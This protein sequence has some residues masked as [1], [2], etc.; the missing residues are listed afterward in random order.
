MPLPSFLHAVV[1]EPRIASGLFADLTDDEAAFCVAAFGDGS[2][3]LDIA[4]HL[5]RH[6]SV[7]YRA[8]H[9]AREAARS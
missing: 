4:T 2:D 8:I 7:V 5:F 6:E 3:T 9:R 1:G